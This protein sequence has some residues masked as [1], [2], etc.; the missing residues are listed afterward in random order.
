MSG[1]AG[2]LLAVPGRRRRARRRDEMQ[3]RRPSAAPQLTR[4]LLAFGRKQVLEPRV[5]DLNDVVASAAG[6]LRRV[7]GDDI[8]LDT[9]S[10]PRLADH[11]RSGQLEQVAR[12]TWR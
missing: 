3:R 4:Q 6:M 9:R 2:V 1:Y 10:T 12:S 8:E 7:L 11:G 5:L